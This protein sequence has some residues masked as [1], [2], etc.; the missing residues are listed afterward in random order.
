[1]T[2]GTSRELVEAYFKALLSRDPLRI[3]QILHDDI[4]WSLGGPIDLLPFC[5][6]R[7]GRNAVV[8]TLVRHV[9][10]VRNRRRKAMSECQSHR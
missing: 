9:P 4:E 7:S 5:G 6:Q 8:E 2:T 10:S 3:A 1:M